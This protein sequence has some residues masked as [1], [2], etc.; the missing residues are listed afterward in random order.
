[1]IHALSILAHD[2]HHDAWVLDVDA[3][4]QHRALIYGLPTLLVA[5]GMW[6]LLPRGGRGGKAFGTVLTLAGLGLFLAGSQVPRLVPWTDY[7][8]FLVLA[9]VTVGSCAA[10]ISSRN[11]VYAAIW[12]GLALLGTGGLFLYQGAQFLG[13]ATV[14]VYAGAIL[15]TFLFVLMLAQPEGQ[16]YYDRLSWEALGSAAIGA[17]MVGMLSASVGNA[18]EGVTTDD[19]HLVAVQAAAERE[20]AILADEHVAHLGAQLFSRHLI[21]VEIGGTLLLAALVGAVAMIAHGSDRRAAL[22]RRKISE[23]GTSDA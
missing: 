2:A 15:V 17:V 8:I 3:W 5:L 11:P 20:A 9:V 12:F 1:M 4:S 6:R 22:E 16:A 7:S 18:L 14:V 23:G 19:S 21:A 13:V 10:S